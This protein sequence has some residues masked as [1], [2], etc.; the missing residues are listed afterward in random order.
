MQRRTE[1]EDGRGKYSVFF[2]YCLAFFFWSQ[3][4]QAEACAYHIVSQIAGPVWSMEESGC[5]RGPPVPE[6]L[7]VFISNLT[8]YHSSLE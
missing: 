6:S 4:F 2:S 8:S 5:D 7:P 3:R 1:T